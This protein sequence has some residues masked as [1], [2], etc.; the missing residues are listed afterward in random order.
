M[1][2]P[3]FPASRAAVEST[4]AVFDLRPTTGSTNADLLDAAPTLSDG[5]VVVTLD[6]T[7]GRGRLDRTWTAPAGQTLAASLLVR[8]PLDDRD[9]GWLPLVAGA[10]MRDA[11][12]AALEPVPDD[13]PD[14]APDD[15]PDAADTSRAS[16]T[17]VKWPNDVLVDGRKICGILCQVA[18]DGSVVVGAGVNLT[19]PEADLPTPTSTSLLASG[20]TGDAGTLADAV[21]SAFWT[22]VREAVVA[23]AGGGAAAEAVR[24]HVRAGCGTIGARVRLELPDGSVVE[25]DATGIDDEGRITIRDQDGSTRGVAVGDV[26]HL[27]YA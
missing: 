2:T 4:G 17:T 6:Q 19:I 5:S 25:A 1:S 8:A 16:R 3:A 27:R 21:L 26:T 20:A 14:Q 11:V 10:A 18:A 13:V 9:R 12:R 22:G 23:L 15:V 7:A 24:S